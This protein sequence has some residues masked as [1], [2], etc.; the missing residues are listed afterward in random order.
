VTTGDSLL[1]RN[2]VERLAPQLDD[3]PWLAPTSR[4]RI[5]SS[6]EFLQVEFVAQFVL[7]E[8]LLRKQV[9]NWGQVG[10]EA[11]VAGITTPG[12]IGVRLASITRQ[13]A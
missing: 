6:P 9:C 8:T 3:P 10:M 2:A 1:H 13:L 7:G 12:R 11:A 5:E 4:G